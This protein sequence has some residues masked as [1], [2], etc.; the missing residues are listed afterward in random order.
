MPRMRS[1]ESS[2]TPRRK[3]EIDAFLQNI[4]IVVGKAQPHLDIGILLVKLGNARG[5]EAAAEA[6]RRGDADDALGLARNRCNR[7]LGVL[8]GLDDAAGA[9]IEDLAVFGRRQLPCGAVEKA[10]AEI[11][12]Q[13]L[14]A[15]AGNGR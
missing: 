12:F 5:N 1:D 15:V 10:H 13:L 14:D 7:R 6:E 2:I 4:D 11:F 3:G 8:D 9:A